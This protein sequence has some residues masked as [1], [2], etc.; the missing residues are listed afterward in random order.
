M[1]MFSK[2]V[3]ELS[4]P[5]T[6][7]ELVAS[8]LFFYNF[9]WVIYSRFFHPYHDIPGPFLAS[10]SEWWYFR[11]IRY[12]MGFSQLPLHKR[13]GKFVRIAPNEVSICDATAL[14]TI[15]GSNPIYKKTEFYDSFSPR[16]GDSVDVFTVRDEKVH[17]IARRKLAPLFTPGAILEYEPC[18]E[19]IVKIFCQ[20]LDE[21]S[22]SKDTIDLSLYF[23]KYSF[24]A[25][26]EIFYG[27]ENGF[28][29]LQDD[30]DYM[31]WMGMLD[32]M[33]SPVSSLAYIPKG[34]RTLYLILQ[35]ALS[36]D[37]RVGLQSANKVIEQ[38][39][40]VVKE[41]QDAFMAGNQCARKDIL[42]KLMD[43]AHSGAEKPDFTLDDVATTVW[44]M[45]WGGSDTTGYAICSI[46]YYVLKHTEVYKK[47]EQE[48]K[49]AFDTGKLSLPIR[50]NDA[51]KLP[52]LNACIKE[53]MRI[54][55]SFGLGLPRY[56]PKGGAVIAGRYFPEGYRVIMNQNV[57][58]FDKECFGKDAEQFIPERWLRDGKEQTASMAR[59]DM[60]FG[61]GPRVCI[62]K[63]VSVI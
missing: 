46:F 27:K 45:I 37:T 49:D 5:L 14:D 15:Y 7:A 62:G 25:I 63:H 3:T 9:T 31:G 17:A 41:R 56:V 60:G 42:S 54:S 52:Y 24:D 35:L 57:V 4:D 40:G 58:H 53:G 61:L 18:V 33:A 30:I 11:V 36:A 21:F 48:L 22:T 8:I 38:A 26:G 28:G 19:R 12:D 13:Y 59:H 50:Y 34:M 1:K 23:R 39:K 43:M 29:F 6:L 10:I 32:V 55:P 20:R 51:V 16:I 47:L 44:M 2:V